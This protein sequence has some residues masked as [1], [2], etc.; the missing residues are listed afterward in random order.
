VLLFAPYLYLHISFLILGLILIYY[1]YTLIRIFNLSFAQ[2]VL[3]SL[4]FGAIVLFLMIAIITIITIL[5]INGFIDISQF[6]P[7]S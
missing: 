4:L 7:Q 3:K 6:A 2:F 5:V 1:A